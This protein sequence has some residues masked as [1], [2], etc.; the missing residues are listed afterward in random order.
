MVPLAMLDAI[1]KLED[2]RG[3]LVPVAPRDHHV[4]ALLFADGLSEL[5][6]LFLQNI[7]TIYR[8]TSKSSFEQQ[9]T[10]AHFYG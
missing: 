3:H 9:P 8:L 4:L 10:H 2:W 6:S 1:G 5:E 7:H